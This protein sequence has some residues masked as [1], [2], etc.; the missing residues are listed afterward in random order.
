MTFLLTQEEIY[1]HYEVVSLKK[2]RAYQIPSNRKKLKA[3]VYGK[4]K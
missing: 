4:E 2:L 3:L 1:N